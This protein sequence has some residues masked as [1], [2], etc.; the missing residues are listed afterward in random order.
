MISRAVRDQLGDRLPVEFD[1][2][3]DHQVG[4]LARVV[5]VFR[6]RLK[7]T[8][9][10]PLRLGRPKPAAAPERAR[11]LVLR[12]Q[13]LSHEGEAEFFLD[14]LAEDLITELSK[15]RWFSVVARNTSFTLKAKPVEVKQLARDLDVRYA[16]EGSLRKSGDRVRVA[17]QLVHA[18]TS[19]HLWAERFDGTLED[20]F[21]LQDQIIAR[22]IGAVAPTIRA[23]EIERARRK[24]EPSRDVY[25]LTLLA[26]AAAAMA[27]ADG[28][29]EAL[30]L[31][32]RALDLD[33]AYPTANAV[34]AWC[35]QQRHLL[36][37]PS[38][39][40]EDRDEAKRLARLA[41]AEDTEAPLA[42]AAAGAVRAILTRDHDLAEAAVARAVSLDPNSAPALSFAALT[43][44]IC[45]KYALAAA[46]ADRAISLS[47]VEPLAYIARFA[48]AIASLA[49]GQ[50]EEAV[51]HG[52]AAINAN[53]NFALSY[54]VLAAAYLRAGRSAEAAETLGEAL[55][56]APGLRAGS[57]RRVRFSDRAIIAE[58]A[59]LRSAGLP[60]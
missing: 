38:A 20:S 52:Q 21:D 37:W 10:A 16:L 49:M 53:H 5:R 1:D 26:L 50:T 36:D 56:I 17:C 47:P 14:S 32:A 44:C 22:V 59:A 28:T 45:G 12:F 2:V 7:Q 24:P 31:T 3:G 11:V 25:D 60:D 29:D 41:I 58:M 54:A 57:F 34:A 15:A 39:T 40:S 6:L 13:N 19:E 33:P 55:R 43:R 42:L 51:A 23:A 48:R 27:T 9:A 8:G 46:H 35:L 30:R 4:D 18:V